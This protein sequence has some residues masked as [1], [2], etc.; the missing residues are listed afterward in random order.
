L[1]FACSLVDI[2]ILSPR[3]QFATATQVVEAVQNKAL[4]TDET[5]P[6]PGILKIL[7][8]RTRFENH[9]KINEAVDESSLNFYLLAHNLVTRSD[10]SPVLLQ[11]MVLGNCV[12]IGVSNAIVCDSTFIDGF[13]AERGVFNEIAADALQQAKQEYQ[14]AFIAWVLGHELGHVVAGDGGAHFGVANVLQQQRQAAIELTQQ[15]ETNADLYAA[16]Q[17][18]KDKRLTGFLEEMLIALVN[19]EVTDK[20]GKPL[21]YGVG[22]RWDYANGSVIQYFNNQDHPEF[23]IRATRMLGQIA[24]D[25]RDDALKALIDTFSRHLVAVREGGL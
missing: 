17:I 16:K 11:S 21:S 13:L 19:Q 24:T 20:N 12:F 14:V 18:A 4:L 7:V 5:G 6:I 25:T 22:L 2:L 23:V 10:V 15:N 1:V 8:S 3:A 9:V